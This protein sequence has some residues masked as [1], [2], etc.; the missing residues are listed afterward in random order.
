VAVI[1]ALLFRLFYVNQKLVPHFQGPEG[2]YICKVIANRIFR[3]GGRLELLTY[4]G[5][6]DGFQVKWSELYSRDSRFES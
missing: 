6:P 3:E 5:N 4:C 1:N 2:E